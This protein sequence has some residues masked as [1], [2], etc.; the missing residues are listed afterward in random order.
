M[1]RPK[2]RNVVSISNPFGLSDDEM[3]F[4][5]EFIAEPTLDTRAAAQRAFLPPEVGGRFLA[6]PKV[7]RYISMVKSRQLSRCEV[8]GDAILRSWG[9]LAGADPAELQYAYRVNCRHCWGMD[10]LYQ[11]D[12][13]E[14]QDR[15]REHLILQERLPEEQRRPF[16]DLG[17]AEFNPLREP[18]RGPDWV[19]LQRRTWPSGLSFVAQANSD[20]SCPRCGG[21][22]TLRVVLRDTTALSPA[23]KM[24]FDGYKVGPN[25]QVEVK[26]RDRFRAEEN[27]AKWAGLFNE[28][29]QI[30]EFDP[31][32][33]TDEQLNVVVGRL[34]ERGTIEIDGTASQLENIVDAESEPADD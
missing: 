12:A 20:H 6:K 10:H 21:D 14:Y 1:A 23:G 3:R 31:D 22:G 19:E 29:R 9:V 24:L 8:Y 25:G 13:P 16:N 4:A 32:R 27:I 2:R 11:F 17:G 28:R 26:M 5:N 15:L 34:V 18:M 7:Q 33:L 30:E